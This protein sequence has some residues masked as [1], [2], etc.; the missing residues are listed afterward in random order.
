MKI[1]KSVLFFA[2]TTL[3]TA[4]IPLSG[5]FMP[6]FFVLSG[7]LSV[8]LSVKWN[9]LYCV[10]SAAFSVMIIYFT[11]GF[12]A[13]AG[14]I[15][16]LIFPLIP[17]IS[18]TGIYIA[19]KSKASVKTILLSGTISYFLLIAF[20]YFLYGG[21]FIADAINIIRNVMF[22]SID[23]VA[24]SIPTDSADMLSQVR[25]MYEVYFESLKIV[26]PSIILSFFFLISYLTIKVSGKLCKNN[27]VFENIPPFSEVRA[28]SF[29][30][31]IFV[32]SY[33]ANLSEN[34]F[35]SG[36]MSNVFMALSFYFA[37]CGLSLIDF[38]T[39]FRIKKLY[40]RIIVYLAGIT[41]LTILSFV[42]YFTN[43]VLLAMFGGLIDSIFNYRAR[44]RM[45]KGK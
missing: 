8:A 16:S 30:L 33:F 38:F 6:L 10:F 12:T 40:V 11:S 22:E 1:L 17:F 27:P 36:L 28:P 13:A 14:I 20:A 43:P 35:V 37:I 21:T 9:Y 24:Q 34:G 32:I 2:L 42:F 39:K 7:A 26:A 44:I 45:L 18:A 31:V 23:S 4:L 15:Y 41:L 25:Q 5:L 19:L 3:T 29:L